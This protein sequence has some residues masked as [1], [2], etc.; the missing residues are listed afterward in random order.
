MSNHANECHVQ[1]GDGNVHHKKQFYRYLLPGKLEWYNFS[2][3]LTYGVL[4]IF[5]IISYNDHTHNSKGVKCAIIA[6]E[7]YVL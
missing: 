5:L 7:S 6:C 4:F 1:D 3:K 2:Q